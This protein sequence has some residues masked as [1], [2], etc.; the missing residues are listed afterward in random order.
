MNLRQLNSLP[1]RRTEAIARHVC[2]V[3]AALAGTTFASLAVALGML[4]VQ[5]H[6]PAP[7]WVGIAVL[8]IFAAFCLFMVQNL[9]RESFTSSPE[10]V[11]ARLQ[12]QPLRSREFFE[13]AAKYFARRLRAIQV[14]GLFLFFMAVSLAV[15]P[16]VSPLGRWMAIGFC[17]LSYFPL[18]MGWAPFR[19]GA[20][21]L[22]LI[23][24]ARRLE[25]KYQ[26][27][28]LRFMSTDNRLFTTDPVAMHISR[29]LRDDGDLR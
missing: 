23:R 5:R 19:A 18:A 25:P 27:D 1:G 6:W 15:L 11:I 22:R 4:S 21:G 12:A 14:S 29:V 10:K 16:L 17:L 20:L 7:A 24:V 8:A 2:M 3:L 9:W 28:A 26:V 13:I